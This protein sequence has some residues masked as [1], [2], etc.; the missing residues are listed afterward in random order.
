MKAKS[1]VLFAATLCTVSLSAT[2]LRPGV[3]GAVVGGVTGG[4]LGHQIGHRDA[5]IVL[6]AALGG[7]SDH[8]RHTPVRQHVVVVRQGPPLL[9]REEAQALQ[10]ERIRNTIAERNAR[11]LALYQWMPAQPAQVGTP[12]AGSD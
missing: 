1:I 9:S 10:A 4:V 7:W 5:G 3:T 8:R 2:C 11:D 6:G 12:A